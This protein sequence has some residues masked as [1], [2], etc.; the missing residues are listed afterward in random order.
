M[1]LLKYDERVLVF[2]LRWKINR[3]AEIQIGWCNRVLYR[4]HGYQGK[5]YTIA[6]LKDN[7]AVNFFGIFF[8]T[9]K[10]SLFTVD[11]KIMRKK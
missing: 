10:N 5:S 7:P 6:Y 1:G 4:I 2:R 8:I 11:F 3:V 9:L